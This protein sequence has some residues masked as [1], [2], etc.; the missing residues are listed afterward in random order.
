MTFLNFALTVFASVALVA[1]SFRVTVHVLVSDIL[2][3]VG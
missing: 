3:H 1:C 2:I